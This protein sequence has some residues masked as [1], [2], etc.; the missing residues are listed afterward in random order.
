MEKIKVGTKKS[1]NDLSKARASLPTGSNSSKQ[2]M[3]PGGGLLRGEANLPEAVDGEDLVVVCWR[4]LPI[5][6]PS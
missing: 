4:L 1:P 2:W 6:P 3:I 5:R